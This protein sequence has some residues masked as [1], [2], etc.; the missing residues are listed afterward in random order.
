MRPSPPPHF[1]D[2]KK[3]DKKWVKDNIRYYWDEMTKHSKSESFYNARDRYHE[4]R[5]YAM[6]DQ[7]IDNY[8]T[9]LEVEDD[10]SWLNIDWKPF[11][12]MPKIRR[13]ALDLLR[14]VSYDMVAEAIDPLAKKK[15]AEYQAKVKSNIKTREMLGDIPGLMMPGGEGE[16]QTEEELNIEMEYGFKLAEATRMEQFIQAVKN[17]NGYDDIEEELHEHLFDYGAACVREYLDNNGQIKLECHHPGDVVVMPGRKKDLSDVMA[18]G[19]IKRMTI[20]DFRM[21]AGNELTEEEYERIAQVHAGKKGNPETWERSGDNCGFDHFKIEVLDMCF[22]SVNSLGIEKR[23]NKF[24]NN[25]VRVREPFKNKGY[26]DRQFS[27]TDYKVYYQG[28]WVIGTEMYYGCGLGKDMTGRVLGDCQLPFILYAPEMYNGKT[29]SIMDSAKNILDKLCIDWYK[30]QNEI[31][32]ARPSGGVAINMD[33][34][35]EVAFTGKG[36]E[37]MKPQELINFWRKKNI[38]L[39]RG[40]D[41]EGKPMQDSPIK[42]SPGGLGDGVLNWWNQIQGKIGLL[43]DIIGFN[44]IT[45]GSSVDPRMLNGVAEK[46]MKST[47]S[48]LNHIVRSRKRIA[49][50]VADSIHLRIKDLAKQGRLGIYEE[51][52]GTDTIQHVTENANLTLHDYAIKLEARPTEQERMELNQ[53]VH[54]MLIAGKIDMKSY[55]IV[56]NTPNIKY[57]FQLLAHFEKKFAEEQHQRALELQ[58]ANAQTQQQSALTAEQAKQQTLQM[59]FEM[60]GGLSAQEHQQKMEQLA[61]QLQIS[62]E[63]KMMELDNNLDEREMSSETSIEV[64]EIQA[65]ANMYAANKRTE[66]AKKSGAAVSK[67]K[68]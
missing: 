11:P 66:Q 31:A 49:E 28:K 58:E 42:E 67:P 61:F 24:G 60:Q 22:L 19:V 16:P 37:N 33:A 68:K 27:R 51:A 20:A 44:E 54:E 21:D 43:R 64:A 56:K 1:I 40:V 47:T 15:K 13:I 6:A 29:Y 48:A 8:K 63:I 53:T 65:G 17:L 5:L 10:S 45:E 32:E 34:L 9:E 2:P 52:V 36:G 55:A 3:K 35:A 12:I 23:T 39:Y 59:Q 26:S 18:V 4:N 46:M 57:A 14:E 7:P 25:E 41:A 38:L 50:K 30:L 62:K